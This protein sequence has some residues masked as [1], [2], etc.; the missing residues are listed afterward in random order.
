MNSPT[1]AILGAAGSTGFGPADWIVLI[2]YF[3]L[4]VG[5]GVWLSRRVSDARDYFLAG[6]A[7]PAW[8]VSISVLATSLSAAT[9]IGAP[10]QSYEGDLTYLSA[11][12]G[13]IVASLVVSVFFIPAFYRHNV[14]TVYELLETRFGTSARRA[15][16]GMFMIGRIFASGARVYIAAHALSFILFGDIAPGH[17]LIAVV[18]LTAAGILYTIAGGIETVI[19][20]DVIQTCVFVAAIVGAVI[21][22]MN[23][24]PADTGEIFRALTTAGDGGKSKL[25]VVSLSTDPAVPFTLWTALTGFTLFNIAALGTDQ[26]LVQRMLT[27]RSAG[28]ASWSVISSQLIGVPVVLV[29]MV[30]GLLLYVLYQRPDLMGAAATGTEAPLGKQVFLQFIITQMP[31]G[32]SGLMI[33]GLFAIALASFDSALNA[34]S[35]TF[36]SDFYRPRRPGLPEAHYLRVA[37]LGVVGWGLVLGGFAALCVWWQHATSERTTLLEFALGVMVYA[38]TGLLAVFLCALLTRRGST[39]SV[40]TALATGFLVTLALEPAV[41]TW[42]TS[43]AEATRATPGVDDG[44]RLGELRLAF[45]WRM[46]V[47]TGLALVVC[48]ASP[49]KANTAA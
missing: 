45:P 35:S 10:Q 17:L 8:A 11:I 42:W 23:R 13:T 9:F 46:V 41:L 15:S 20:T 24:I 49:G 27:C 21:V 22:L 48:L 14:S 31:Q 47:A 5:T 12:L 36:V 19:W 2:A 34:M 37:R 4:L 26:D 40:L 30:L 43:L 7:M 6:R 18:A 38:Y 39:R 33:A 44:F 1:V 32:M 28:R 16:S 25:T 29:F 3:A